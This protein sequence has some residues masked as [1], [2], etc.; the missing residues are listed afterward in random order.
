MRWRKRSYCG[1]GLCAALDGHKGSCA[2]ASGWNMLYGRHSEDWFIG[3]G[4]PYITVH[5]LRLRD[6]DVF[7][8]AVARLRV[9]S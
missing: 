8:A 4:T 1:K 6:D 3:C 7:K 2:E 9:V 5:H